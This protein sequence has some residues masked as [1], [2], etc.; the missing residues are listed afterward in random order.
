MKKMEN[1]ITEPTKAFELCSMVQKYDQEHKQRYI[2]KVT[3]VGI[4]LDPYLISDNLFQ[5]HEDWLYIPDV[6]YPDIY[7]YL[8]NSKSGYTSQA[9]KAYKSL[10]GYKYFVAGFVNELKKFDVSDTTSL[11][12]SKVSFVQ[13]FM[14][15]YGGV[16]GKDG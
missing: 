3:L 10:D 8:I 15:S 5:A 7:N 1:Q 9:L 6:Q 2:A 13:C 14:C 11:I 12:I 16:S 4:E